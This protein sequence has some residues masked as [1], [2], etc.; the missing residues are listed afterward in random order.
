M[1]AQGILGPDLAISHAPISDAI[2]RVAPTLHGL[3]VAGIAASMLGWV[4][5][6]AMASPRSLFAF[7]RDGLLPALLGRVHR[8]T[9]APHLAILAYATATA[10]LAVSGS[11]E[12]LA[13]LATLLVIVVYL[14][15]CAAALRLRRMNVELAGPVMRIPGLHAA[16]AL[17]FAT[18]IWLALQSSAGE[19]RATTGLVALVSLLYLFRRRS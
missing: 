5:G 4:A 18:M 17:S 14:V 2:A 3:V 19:A 10:A 7:A 8:R 16:A 12:T 13:V 1:I 15:G 6:D 11:F 9:H